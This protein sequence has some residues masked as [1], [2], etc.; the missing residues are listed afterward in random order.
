[1]TE[2]A[3]ALIERN[4]PVE[5]DHVG[6]GFAHGGQQGRGVHSEVDDR[7]AQRLDPAHQSGVR[8][9]QNEVAI[10]GRAEGAD[11]AIEDL[12][13]ICACL[14]LLGGVCSQTVAS[15]SS[16]SCQT[17]GSRYIMFLVKT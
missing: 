11:P 3:P 17:A 4:A 15:F 14:H 12:D 7:N 13:D 1:M 16:R 6:A 5:P 8:D 2:R 10:I 9:G